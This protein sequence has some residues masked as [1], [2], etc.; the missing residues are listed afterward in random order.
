MQR[1]LARDNRRRRV[2]TYKHRNNQSKGFAVDYAL[3][4]NKTLKQLAREHKVSLATIY[5][6]KARIQP[7][8]ARI[9][10]DDVTA[11]RSD[12]LLLKDIAALTGLSITSVWR[13]LHDD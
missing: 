9:T 6:H 13:L 7:R 11:L 5:R 2:H 12:G 3:D 8:Q 1:M 4:P 10:K